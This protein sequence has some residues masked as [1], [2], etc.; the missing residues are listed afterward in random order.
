MGRF[1]GDAAAVTPVCHASSSKQAG[2][3]VAVKPFHDANGTFLPGAAGQLTGEL[4]K[5]A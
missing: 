3:G 4:K 1:M 5:R 2:H